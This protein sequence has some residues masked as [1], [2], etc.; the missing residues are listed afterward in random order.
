MC[1]RSL[2]LR[3]EGTNSAQQGYLHKDKA[4]MV[5]T[6]SINNMQHDLVSLNYGGLDFFFFNLFMYLFF[7]GVC[8]V[9]FPLNV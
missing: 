7:I 3:T 9:F 5:F 1:L 2:F 6:S 8:C 4:E